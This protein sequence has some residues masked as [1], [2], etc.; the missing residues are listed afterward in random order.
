MKN[1]STVIDKLLKSEGIDLGKI[2]KESLGDMV[3]QKKHKNLDESY[4]SKEKQFSQVTEFVS[5]ST[6]DAHKQV[7]QGFVES[8]NRVSNELD[9]VK[10]ESANSAHS[11][12]RSL[13]LDESFNLNAKWLHELYFGN[14]FDPNS[15]LYMDS[16][17][18]IKLQRDFGTFEEWQQDFIACAMSCGNGWAILGY[19]MHLQK[20][21]NTIVSNNSQDTMVGLYPVIVVDMHEH[22]HRDYLNDKKSYLVSMM[23]EFHWDI[24]DERFNKSENI[25]KVLK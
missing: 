18:Y 2:V 6:K 14:C 23:K 13:K 3:G 25:A 15:E 20:Y 5:Q 24:I 17:S 10:K 4:V 22:A 19:N 16:I 1:K 8:S 21:V 12:Y 7:Y 11:D 9:S